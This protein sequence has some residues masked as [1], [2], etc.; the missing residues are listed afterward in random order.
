MMPE[1]QS[2]LNDV[3]KLSPEQKGP[4]ETYLI[5]TLIKDVAYYIIIA[6]VAWA[7]GRRLIHALLSAYREAKRERA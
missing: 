5:V 7:L 4:Y 1:L 3:S 6:I 2:L